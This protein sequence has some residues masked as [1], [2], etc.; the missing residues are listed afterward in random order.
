MT[1]PRTRTRRRS[2][3]VKEATVSAEIV[4]HVQTVYR[5]NGEMNA[6]KRKHDKARKELFSEMKDGHLTKISVPYREGKNEIMLEAE[7]TVP[8]VM[9]IDMKKLQ[10]LVTEDQW[11]ELVGTTKGAIEAVA[12]KNVANQVI[13]YQKAPEKE[14][15]KVGVR[16]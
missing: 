14:N 12:G 3:E 15:V 9:L 13:T 1:T 11:M 5:E 7:I 8:D 4:N 6:H 16:K 2:V 10:G